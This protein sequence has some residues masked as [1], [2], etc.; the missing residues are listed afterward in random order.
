[1]V[2]ICPVEFRRALYKVIRYILPSDSDEFFRL[3]FVLGDTLE[4][5]KSAVIKHC[6]MVGI[7]RYHIHDL[8]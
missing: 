5:Q 3:Y 7:L 8:R 2:G 6:D 1:M 4:H